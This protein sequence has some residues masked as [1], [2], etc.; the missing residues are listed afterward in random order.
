MLLRK[1]GRFGSAWSNVC[2]RCQNNV[3]A[4]EMAAEDSEKLMLVVSVKRIGNKIFTGVFLRY[5]CVHQASRARKV[6]GEKEG[7]M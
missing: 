2:A 7:R 3:F 4:P 1:A 5:E 6:S